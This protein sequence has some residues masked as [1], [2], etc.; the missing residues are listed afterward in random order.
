MIKYV[1]LCVLVMLSCETSGS[2]RIVNSEFDQ[3]EKTGGTAGWAPGESIVLK[4]D[5]VPDE[6][7]GNK[8]RESFG[9]LPARENI[10]AADILKCSWHKFFTV[11]TFSEQGHYA[12]GDYWSGADFGSYTFEDNTITFSPPLIVNRFDEHYRID[13]LYY[14]HEPHYEGAPVLTNDDDTVVFSAHDNEKP[15]IGSIVKINQQYCELIRENTKIQNNILLALPDLHSKNLFEDNYYG[16]KADEAAVIKLAKTEKD[17]VLW[18]YVFVDFT[19][20][21]PSDGGGPYY[22]GWVSE[23]HVE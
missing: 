12:V 11:L 1:L 16:S 10:G 19:G 2:P 17:G 5:A 20:D 8:W 7:K 9:S 22:Y 3:T 21:E 14:S 23:D 18:Y 13:K 6:F 4:T 15:E